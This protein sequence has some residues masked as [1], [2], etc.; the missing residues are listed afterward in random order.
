M[1]ELTEPL[2]NLAELPPHPAHTTGRKIERVLEV[3]DATDGV[4]C[5]AG[6]PRNELSLLMNGQRVLSHLYRY[7]ILNGRIYHT[8]NQVVCVVKCQD[9]EPKPATQTK[10]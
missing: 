3:R 7:A 5:T 2:A 6:L 4:R 1:E 10:S 9:L 8:R